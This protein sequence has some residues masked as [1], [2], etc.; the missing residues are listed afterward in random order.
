M[1]IHEPCCEKGYL[2]IQP[3]SETRSA[4][5]QS[6]RR[7]STAKSSLTELGSQV[8]VPIEDR[9]VVDLWATKV[10]VWNSLSHNSDHVYGLP[11]IEREQSYLFEQ[12][13]EKKLKTCCLLQTDQAKYFRIIHTHKGV[14]S[15]K[16]LLTPIS[17][18]TSKKEWICYFDNKFFFF[19]SVKCKKR[20]GILK[21]IHCPYHWDQIFC[22]PHTASME[23]KRAN[24]CVGCSKESWSV[25]C[26]GICCEVPCFFL[27]HGL[28]VKIII[29]ACKL[30]WSV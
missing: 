27:W 26:Q 2:L 24:S 1:T 14:I 17:W 15:V 4:C 7:W 18:P 9:S 6:A 13:Y 25:I 5:W 28:I 8:L 20:P 3:V 16:M 30:K 21:C 12:C 11:T 22:C 23:Y 29:Y 19:L 10:F